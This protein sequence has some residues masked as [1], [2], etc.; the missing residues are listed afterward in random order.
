MSAA[1]E[2]IRQARTRAG[3]TQHQLAELSGVRQP[4]VA[5][6][7]NGQRVPSPRM[8]ER[9]LVAARPRPSKVLEV[10]REQIRQIAGQHRA[11]NVR[12]FGSVARGNDGPDSDLDFLV[13]FDEEASLL[14][15]A[16]LNEDLEE[17]L[18]VPVHVVSD[19]A[20]RD[21][22]AQIAREAVAV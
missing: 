4:N 19:R 2:Q 13:T 11:G 7:E 12:V 8:L 9:L 16:A 3:L 21:R 20:L 6:Y 10:H 22:D 15:Q 5:A 14:D 17:V 1:G 18:G